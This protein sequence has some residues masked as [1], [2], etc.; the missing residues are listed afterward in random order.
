MLGKLQAAPIRIDA[1][2]PARTP[3]PTRRGQGPRRPT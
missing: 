2:T 3:R 1:D